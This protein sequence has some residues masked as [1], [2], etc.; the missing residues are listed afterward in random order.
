MTMSSTPT[1]D[2]NLSKGTGLVEETLTLL[3]AYEPGMSKEDFYDKVFQF[4]LLGR[5]TE[6]RANDIVKRVFFRRYWRDDNIDLP[7]VLRKLRRQHV[8]I[9]VIR[10][11]FLIYTCRANPILRDFLIEVY[12]PF[13]EKGFQILEKEDFIN[14]IRQGIKEGKIDPPWSDSVIQR[15]GRYLNA[16]LQDFGFID[17]NKNVLP[18]Q[19]F[20]TTANYLAHE[21]HFRGLTDNQ[22]LHHPDW[23]IFNLDTHQVAEQLQR[24]SWEGHFIFQYSGELLKISWK[25]QTMEA[26]ID[27]LTNH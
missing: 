26:F 19:I 3:E 13:I 6:T 27:G 1:Y 9:N 25:Y 4:D 17:E 24:I 11:I 2:S 5:T 21:L 12:F 15:V 22:M 8:S 20:Q 10:Q 18:F 16:T 14:F 7:L 23:K